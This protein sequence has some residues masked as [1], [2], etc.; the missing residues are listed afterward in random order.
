MEKKKITIYD[1]AEK[2]SVSIATVNRAL[3]GK[4]KVSEAVRK[5]VIEVANE[6]GY[7]ASITAASLSR[8]PIKIGL[9]T[10]KDRFGFINE[11]ECGVKVVFEEL[12]DYK[13]TSHICRLD[14]FANKDEIVSAMWRMVHSGCNGIAVV[15]FEDELIYDDTIR[16]IRKEG[17]VIGTGISDFPSSNRD[18]SVRS[19]GIIAGKMAAQLLYWLVG[20]EPVAIVTGNRDLV[21]HKETINGF[22]Q[23]AQEKGMSVAGIYE[24]RDDKQIAYHLASKMLQERPD[25]KGIYFGSANSVSFCEKLIELGYGKKIC[26]VASDTLPM[27][28][29]FLKQGIINATIFQNPFLQGKTLIK[30]IYEIITEND[31]SKKGIHYLDPEVVL[32]SNIEIYET[33]I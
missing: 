10:S 9:L 4:P 20:N 21:V 16:E 5:R 25:I 31:E 27:I 15:P 11:F 3:N 33:V 12:E 17:V 24:H 23:Y 8:K 30:N 26:I 28:L 2:L 1:V 22:K 6:M 19:N 14:R 7:K 13:V 29:D 18:L 32:A